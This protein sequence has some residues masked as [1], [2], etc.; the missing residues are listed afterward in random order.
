MYWTL[1]VTLSGTQLGNTTITYVHQLGSPCPWG[2]K[3]ARLLADHNKRNNHD[4]T[5]RVN[6]GARPKTTGACRMEVPYSGIVQIWDNFHPLVD[7]LESCNMPQGY[8]DI[9]LSCN[10]ECIQITSWFCYIELS[11]SAIMTHLQRPR[12]WQ[13]CW[14]HCPGCRGAPQKTETHWRRRIEQTGLPGSYGYA[15]I[16]HLPKRENEW[17]SLLIKMT[18]GTGRGNVYK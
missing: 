11:S 6:S 18:E 1:P 9:C 13:Q 14:S 3:I 15:K 5:I 16:G 7:L 12:W 2:W 4:I 17:L 10:V 8:R